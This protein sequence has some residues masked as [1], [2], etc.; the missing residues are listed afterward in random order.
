MNPIDSLVVAAGYRLILDVGHIEDMVAVIEIDVAVLITYD[1][2][3]AG[4][5]IGNRPYFSAGQTM[6]FRHTGQTV[7][8]RIVA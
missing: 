4:R 7:V 2:T 5:M 8:V 3:I 6:A 1:Q